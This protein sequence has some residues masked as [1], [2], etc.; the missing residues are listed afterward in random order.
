MAEL[1]K[2]MYALHLTVDSTVKAHR[3][4]ACNAADRSKH[5]NITESNFFSLDAKAFIGAEGIVYDGV[6]SQGHNSNTLLCLSNRKNRACI[7]GRDASYMIGIFPDG[8]VNA[9]TMIPRVL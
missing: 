3:E 1:Q 4:R 7:A 8:F 5:P 9:T 2:H 6:L